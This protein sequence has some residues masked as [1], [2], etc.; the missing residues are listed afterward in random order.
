M[1]PQYLSRFIF[2]L[3]FVMF[4]ATAHAEENQYAGLVKS[5]VGDVVIHNNEKHVPAQPNMTV[6]KHDI[7]LT[8][9]DSSVGLVFIDDTVLSLGA[10]SEL[11]IEDYEFKPL[12]Q[13]FSFIAQLVKG[14]F[15]FLSGQI[16]DLAPEKVILKTPDATLGVRGTKF[17]VEVN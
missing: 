10:R 12:L 4:S 14:T 8:G 15:S 17:I 11:M 5:V 6:Y 1:R 3:T 13:H 9:A 7:I 16:A 2:T